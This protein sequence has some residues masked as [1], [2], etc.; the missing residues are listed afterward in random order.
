MY[1]SLV[2]W[3]V[4][5]LNTLMKKM[6]FNKLLLIRSLKYCVLNSEVCLPFP[7]QTGRSAGSSVVY[8]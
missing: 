1:F 2:F 5:I 6:G 4:D 8:G 3:A 7:Y